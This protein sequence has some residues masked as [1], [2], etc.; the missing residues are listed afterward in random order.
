MDHAA[1]PGLAMFTPFVRGLVQFDHMQEL[2]TK[3]TCPAL[4]FT[5]GFDHV[6]SS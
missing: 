1:V 3:R 5:V 2:A 6:G 4:T